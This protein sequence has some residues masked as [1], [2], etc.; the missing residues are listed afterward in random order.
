M[1]N[2]AGAILAAVT[3]LPLVACDADPADP[4]CADGTCDELPAGDA[5]AEAR[6]DLAED[7]QLGK[8]L[9]VETQSVVPDAPGAPRH[10]TR[11]AAFT[12]PDLPGASPAANL[13]AGSLDHAGD[14]DWISVLVT[15]NKPAGPWEPFLRV[16]PIDNL[17]GA[18]DEIEVCT[19]ATRVN[20]GPLA[21][22][23]T[24]C[25]MAPRQPGRA[26]I[27]D[28]GRSCCVTSTFRADFEVTEAEALIAKDRVEV[29]DDVVFDLRV[30]AAAGCAAYRIRVDPSGA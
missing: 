14:V 24:T 12:M 15:E 23:E 10:D 11:D 8:F 2:R 13:V 3:L 20:G 30:R 4:A 18:R 19:F 1:I 5:C 27:G 21:F 16:E 28:D 25:R 7:I 17:L 6:A 9:G 29:D 22:D 26:S